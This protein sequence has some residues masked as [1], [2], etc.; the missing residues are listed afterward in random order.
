MEEIIE[1]K[2]QLRDIEGVINEQQ[3]VKSLNYK[4]L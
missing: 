2:K 1:L 3:L 4:S